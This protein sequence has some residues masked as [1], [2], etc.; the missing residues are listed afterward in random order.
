MNFSNTHYLLST[1]TLIL[2]TILTLFE[3]CPLL[4][5]LLACTI[6]KF[7]ATE[8]WQLSRPV[9]LLLC[10]KSCQNNAIEWISIVFFFSF[11]VNTGWRCSIQATKMW[12]EWQSFIQCKYSTVTV[13]DYKTI[14]SIV[15]P[16]SC[17]LSF[18]QGLDNPIPTFQSFPIPYHLNL[19]MRVI[20][21]K[22]LQNKY[23]INNLTY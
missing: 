5:K 12:S 1:G 3:N 10:H 2:T 17:I 11:S 8:D 21:N 9:S 7:T 16:I 13:E 15:Y 22:I 4:P 14:Y 18:K 6:K 19:G 23:F 20:L